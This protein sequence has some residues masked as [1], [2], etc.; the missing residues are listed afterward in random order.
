[1]S[2]AFIRKNMS[3]YSDTPSISIG[4]FLQN[5]FLL[6]YTTWYVCSPQVYV[7]LPASLE[8]GSARK[9]AGL[10][11]GIF[12]LYTP[13]RPSGVVS[14]HSANITSRTESYY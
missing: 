2:I 14:A 12:Y 13:S 10:L 6:S 1:M 7:W 3:V 8:Q 4:K 11:P 5:D 9:A